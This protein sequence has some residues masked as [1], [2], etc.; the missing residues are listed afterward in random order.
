M[1]INNIKEEGVNQI[2][3]AIAYEKESK[4][5]ECCEYYHKG[6]QLLIQYSE[7]MLLF[8]LIYNSIY[9]RVA[10]HSG[11]SGKLREFSN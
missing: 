5:K 10:T 8:F 1:D 7:S 4:F 3:K 6:I 11:N 2:K 9:C